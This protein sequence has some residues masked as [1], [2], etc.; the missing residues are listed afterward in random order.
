MHETLG[1]AV[2]Q[3]VGALCYKPEGREFDPDGVIAI[4][5]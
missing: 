5:H 1:Y 4:F 2:A 3:L